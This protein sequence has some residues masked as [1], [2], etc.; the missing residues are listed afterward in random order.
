MEISNNIDY[1]NNPKVYQFKWIDKRFTTAFLYLCSIFIFLYFGG[2]GLLNDNF[3]GFGLLGATWWFFYLVIALCGIEFFVWIYLLFCFYLIGD[4]GNE[5]SFKGKIEKKPWYFE[6][7]NQHAIEVIFLAI[8]FVTL[9]GAAFGAFNSQA[10]NF[11]LRNFALVFI[12]LW[13]IGYGLSIWK[14]LALTFKAN[15]TDFTKTKQYQYTLIWLIAISFFAFQFENAAAG[16]F[17]INTYRVLTTTDQGQFIINNLVGGLSWVQNN[18]SEATSLIVNV[19]DNNWELLRGK[20]PI[21][22]VPWSFARPI[23]N[24]KVGN[25]VDKIVSI[26]DLNLFVDNLL[27][28]LFDKNAFYGMNNNWQGILMFLTLVGS[29]TGVTYFSYHKFKN[30]S[31]KVNRIWKEA[32][33]VVITF[34]F[35]IFAINSWIITFINNGTLNPGIIGSGVGDLYGTHPGEIITNHVWL[36]II[37]NNNW[38]GGLIG[39]PIFMIFEGSYQGTIYWWTITALMLVGADLIGTYYFLDLKNYKIVDNINNSFKTVKNKITNFVKNLVI[40]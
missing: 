13:M 2:L 15:E 8:F 17:G 36:N 33:I 16:A 35:I 32:S 14:A 20:G 26:S 31:F 10:F 12:I 23:V 5:I 3:F 6:I 27:K 40:E 29:T 39:K 4:Y 7:I 34:V 19:I 38:A 9:N 30:D 22:D 28:T 25:A 18:P 11:G 1:Q 37:F 24:I 21:P